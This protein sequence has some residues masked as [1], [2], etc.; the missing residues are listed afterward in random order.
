MSAG[1][2][3]EKGLVRPTPVSDFGAQIPARPDLIT[4][5]DTARRLLADPSSVLVDVRSWR[6]FLGEVSGYNDLTAKGRIAGAVWGHGGTD[7]DHMEDYRNPDNTLRA[8]RDIAHFWADW[9]ITTKK[10]VGFYCGTCWRAC[11]ALFAAWLMG[12]DNITV[13]DG[14]WYEWSADRS[15][16]VASGDPRP[17]Q[18]Q[19][20]RLPCPAS[21]MSTQA[22]ECAPPDRSVSPAAGELTCAGGTLRRAVLPED[23]ERSEA[24][25]PA[26]L[27][28]TRAPQPSES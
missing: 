13:Y 27:C 16:P 28:R 12:W 14:G 9:G 26:V 8:A 2:S 6:E 17:P 1:L 4:G 3:V 23:T 15:N 11:E 5:I 7:A 10:R 21:T 20:Q 22:A 19:P 18:K 25:L 24:P